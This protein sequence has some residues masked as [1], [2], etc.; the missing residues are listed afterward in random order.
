MFADLSDSLDNVQTRLS[1]ED[2]ALV[3]LVGRLQALNISLEHDLAFL[4]ELQVVLEIL[5]AVSVV[6]WSHY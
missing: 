6:F 2:S 4:G 1:S 3:S 5:E